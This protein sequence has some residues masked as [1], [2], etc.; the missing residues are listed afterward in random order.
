MIGLISPPKLTM[1]FY[2]LTGVLKFSRDNRD[3]KTTLFYKGLPLLNEPMNSVG[4]W[5][6]SIL[7]LFDSLMFFT[8]I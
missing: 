3:S 1:I 7:R 8:V 5:G 2:W 6:D 4:L